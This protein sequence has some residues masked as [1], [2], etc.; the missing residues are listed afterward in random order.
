MTKLEQRKLGRTE[1]LVTPIGIGCAPL[2]D[3][4]VAL[5]EERA[6]QT[7]QAAWDSGVRYFDTAPFYGIGK[8]EH[9]V[10]TFLRQQPRDAFTV[11][12]KVGRILRRPHNINKMEE[13]MWAGGLP[14]E[15]DYDYSYDGIMR[16]Y[17]D[18]LQRL[19]L[20]SIDIL[21]V[22]DLDIYF[23]QSEAKFRAYMDQ[24]VSSG[25]RALD[26]LKGSGQVKAI[27]S[28]INTVDTIPRYLEV[29]D[30]DTFVMAGAY[31]LLEQN[32]LDRELP[33][34]AERG[35][36]VIIGAV[37]A[38]GILATGAIEGAKFMYEPASEDILEKT[39]RI[40]AV[41]R[42]HGTPLTAAALQFLLAHPCVATLIPGA[43]EP[44][45]IESNVEAS[46]LSIPDALWAELKDEGLLREDA[47][48]P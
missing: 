16:S 44:A 47:P 41:C 11:S 5:S 45:H 20:N 13:G 4:F 34:C 42:R 23:H 17:E 33:M 46:Q 29:L 8:S 22:H 48:T 18:S 27:G 12:T 35:I 2:G 24:L 1:A 37:F 21:L 38:S 30:L 32:M 7:L 25:W 43:L 3:L 40:E 9:R 10:G 26:E 36:Q 19:S 31:N 15:F 6:Q 14:F 39:R 28:G